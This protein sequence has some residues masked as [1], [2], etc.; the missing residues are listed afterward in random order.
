VDLCNNSEVTSSTG[1]LNFLLN[2]VGGSGGPSG[3]ATGGPSISGVV[4]GT[5]AGYP[6]PSWQKGVL[7]NP[8]DGVRD[9]PDVSLFASNGFWNTYYVACWSNPDPNVGGGFT[10]ALPP[11]NW[12]GWGGTSI[13]SPIM[14][15][16]QAL[17]DQKTGAKWGNPNPVYY[18]LAKSEYAYPG[19]TSYC[20]SN[21]VPKT[22][23]SCIFYDVTQGDN[24]AVC[25]AGLTG[26][27]VN[28][29]KPSGDTYGVLSVTDYF[30]Y[31]AYFVNPGWDFPS[32][33]GSVNGWNL[34]NEWPSASR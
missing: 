23:N 3:C 14:A 17:I 32:G 9:I 28:C 24:D 29:F 15:G 20:N 7:G 26:L 6:K 1:P 11:S 33:L 4:S 12:S 31:P 22:G 27:L 18:A 21:T 5:C 25:Q 30:D 10:C 13:S 19:G 2:A 8:S 16:I 34:V